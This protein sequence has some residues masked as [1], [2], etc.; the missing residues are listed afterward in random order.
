M[1]TIFTLIHFNRMH[2][3]SQQIEQ[4]IYKFILFINKNKH[5]NTFYNHSYIEEEK[6][7]KVAFLLL[8]YN[9]LP[10]NFNKI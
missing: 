5:F 7:H 4:K 9:L 6:P 3:I 8:I 10:T 1:H 2:P